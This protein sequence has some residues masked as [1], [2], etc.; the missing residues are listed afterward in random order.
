MMNVKYAHEYWTDLGF[1]FREGEADI[2]LTRQEMEELRDRTDMPGSN[3][4]VKLIKGV[5]DKINHGSDIL[6]ERITFGDYDS[7]LFKDIFDTN[8]EF[9][10]GKTYTLQDYIQ[11]INVHNYRL[12]S[13]KNK[14]VININNIEVLEPQPILEE[15]IE[16][17]VLPRVPDALR[18][19]YEEKYGEE[20]DIYLNRDF[21]GT[22]RVY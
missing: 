18:R 1:T 2:L 8:M 22:F 19:D 4:Y 6:I 17:E 16:D 5:I 12:T 3:R 7:K 13:C 21:N 14:P 10:D 11:N 15:I 20:A 9:I